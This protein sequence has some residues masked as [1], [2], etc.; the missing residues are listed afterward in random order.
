MERRRDWLLPDPGITGSLRE[1]ILLR[2]GIASDRERELFAGPMPRLALLHD[3]GTLP[4]ADAV[5]E[6]LDDWIRRGL[7]VAVY[8]DYDADGLTAASIVARVLRL[9]G[10]APRV[11]IPHRIDD[12]YGLNAQALE[13]LH[14]DGVQAVVTVDCGIRSFPEA[15]RAAELGLQLVI[16]DHHAPWR[17]AEGRVELPQ[18]AAIAHPALGGCPFETISGSV[19]ALKVARRLI[20]RRAGDR[21]P[22]ALL[23][24]VAEVGVSLAALGLVPDVMPLL[25]ENRVLVA[26]AIPRLRSGAIPGVL[27][28]MRAAGKQAR[29]IDAGTLAFTLG[30]MLNAAGRLD[31]AT[32]ALQVLE[33]DDPAEAERLAPRLHQLNMQRRERADALAA[34]AEARVRSAGLD[35]ADRRSIA[36]GDAGWHP[37]LIGLA[38]ARLAERFHRPTMVFGGDG[39]VW[40]GSG[41]SVP[42]VDLDACLADCAALLE[43]F[44]GHAAAA[45]GS[46]R[47][48]RFGAFAD[49]FEV[50]VK[51]RMP[52][53][54][55]PEPLRVDA[56]LPIEDALQSMDELESLQP[57]GKG[58]PLPLLHCPDLRVRNASVMGQ[59]GKHL[60]VQVQTA[61]TGRGGSLLMWGEGGRLAEFR[62]GRGLE[63]VGAP[64]ASGNPRFAPDFQVRDLRFVD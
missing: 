9:F 26:Q 52:Q 21:P 34:E 16:T 33:T 58:F 14:R 27:A 54:P 29:D 41:R 53:E 13:E 40:K 17:G 55:R 3:P 64:R 2:R 48:E 19:V 50:A 23:R 4:G 57:F 5:A 42:G 56:S 59:G 20:R 30:P 63:V 12:G 47:P 43:R 37:G 49:A 39:E 38:A 36:V 1:R 28:M 35:A 45:G 11:F 24:W 46:L 32:L 22:D 51:R 18:A 15:R 62:P 25:D 44:G 31:D 10:A 7:R 6:V 8:G 60:K 61:G